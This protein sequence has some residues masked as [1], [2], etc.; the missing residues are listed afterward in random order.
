V[1]QNLLNHMRLDAEIGHPR[2]DGAA[3]I[4]DRP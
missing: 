4:M 1:V 2:R 3:Q